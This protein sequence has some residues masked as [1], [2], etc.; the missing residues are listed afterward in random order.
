[1]IDE[2][3]A[4]IGDIDLHQAEISEVE[5]NERLLLETQRIGKFTCSEF[6]KLMT[7]ENKIDEFPKGAETV[8]IEKVSEILTDSCNFSDSWTNDAMQWGKDHELEAVERFTKETGIKVAKIGIGQEFIEYQG[9]SDDILNGNAGGTPD[10]EIDDKRGLEVKCPDSKTHLNYIIGFKPIMGKEEVIKPTLKEVEKRYY[11]QVQGYM[12]LT[13]KSEWQFVSYDPRFTDKTKQI[14][15]SKVERNETDIQR[16]I[17][18]LR[19]AVRRK[20]ELLK[21]LGL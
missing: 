4:H 15:I 10:G 19:M 3:L 12:L 16:L 21:E 11:W 7:Y 17:V 8:V 6:H 20:N 18:R 1:M 2:E 9:D 5:L 13:G 14:V